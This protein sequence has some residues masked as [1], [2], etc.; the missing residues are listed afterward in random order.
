MWKKIAEKQGYIAIV[1]SII[2]AAIII[3]CIEEMKWKLL[4]LANSILL[5]ING[6]S[7][8]FADLGLKK[9]AL[10]AGKIYKVFSILFIIVGSIVLLGCI[11]GII[12]L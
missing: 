8:C 9:C 4:I 10:V 6:L 1:V 11:L 2:F 12:D 7:L 5:L 3:L